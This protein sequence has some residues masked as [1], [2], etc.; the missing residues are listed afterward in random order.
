MTPWLKRAGVA[1]LAAPPMY[2]RLRRRALRHGSLTV[3]CYHTLRADAEELDA[4]IALRVRD[5]RDQI[6]MLRKSYDIVSLDDALSA[7][8]TGGRPQAVLTFDDGE[9]GLHEYLLP[10]VEE[11]DIPV[12]IYVATSQIE[13]GRPF[14]FDRVM[15]ALQGPTGLTVT[16]ADDRFEIAPGQ[17]VARWLD[18]RDVLEALKRCDPKDRDRLAD[19]VVAQGQAPQGVTPLQPMSLDQLRKV[20]QDP[21]VTIGAHTH[22]HELLD[23]LPLAD[24]L[25]SVAKSRDLLAEWTGRDIRH[26]AYPNGN[27]TADLMTGIADLGLGS[28]TILNDGLAPPS[29]DVFALPRIGVGR[30]DA[31]DRLKLRM[32]GV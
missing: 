30:Y 21:R 23:Q 11:L 3:L 18:I 32:V 8:D 25:L 5:F 16:V 12:T 27:Y 1:A 24:A 17:G 22:G 4:W 28:A 31:L 15:N 6:A 20:A 7:D 10:L 14:W 19:E 26:F 29:A 9:W 2:N 13:T